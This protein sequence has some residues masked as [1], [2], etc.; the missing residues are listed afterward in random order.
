MKLNT[1]N[2]ATIIIA[3]LAL[4]LVALFL[5]PQSP[6]SIATGSCP[7]AEVY[8]FNDERVTTLQ[9]LSN[10]Y[11]T[12]IELLIQAGYEEIGGYVVQTNA[13]PQTLEVS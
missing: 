7:E 13:C 3:I 12:P 2:Q 4:L 10:M 8:D 6:F 9:Q 1:V 5:L 11:D